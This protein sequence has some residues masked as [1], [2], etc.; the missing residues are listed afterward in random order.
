MTTPK[1]HWPKGRHRNP[2]TGHWS[3]TL[4]LLEQLMAEHGQRY[5]CDWEMLC[6]AVG[7]YSKTLSQYRHGMRPSPERQDAIRAWVMQMRAKVRRKK[8]TSS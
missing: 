6:R 7:M 2:D 3:Q 5:V 8:A 4:L 1:G